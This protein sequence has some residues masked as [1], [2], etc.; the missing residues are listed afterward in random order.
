MGRDGVVEKRGSSESLVDSLKERLPKREHGHFYRYTGLDSL[1]RLH[2]N[3]EVSFDGKANFKYAVEKNYKYGMEEL[4]DAE[5]IA[6]FALHALRDGMVLIRDEYHQVADRANLIDEK[7]APFEKVV[8][9]VE[10]LL[11]TRDQ[12]FRG[13]SQAVNETI[14]EQ[15][16]TALMGYF[17][18][19]GGD[20]TMIRLERS[21]WA[22]YPNAAFSDLIPISVG[23]PL[24]LSGGEE[25][26]VLEL[27]FPKDQLIIPETDHNNEHEVMVRRIGLDNITEIYTHKTQL[28][29]GGVLAQRYP[30]FF[31]LENIEDPVVV[32][33]VIEDGLRQFSEKPLVEILDPTR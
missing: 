21:G 2:N 5:T 19:I 22:V 33:R 15:D 32:A 24:Y 25:V 20:R 1:R 9:D 7:S 26:M 31:S 4:S 11:A 3:G 6:F 23:A 30:D 27:D 29:L 28:Q 10:R 8:T 16:T 13:L 17:K 12:K 18:R 14:E